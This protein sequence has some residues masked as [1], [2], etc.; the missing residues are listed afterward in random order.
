MR[1]FHKKNVVDERELMEMFQV[2]HYVCWITFWALL[3]SIFYQLFFVDDSFS[4]VGGEWCVF[5]VMAFGIL[6][7]NLKGGHFDYSSRPGWKYY[8]FYSVIAAV[9]VG[10][11][12]GC[13]AVTAGA[14]P[15]AILQKR[16]ASDLVLA[17]EGLVLLGL[18]MVVVEDIQ[19]LPRC[20]GSFLRDGKQDGSRYVAKGRCFRLTFP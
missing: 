12:G 1:L 16:L 8:L 14:V 11:V 18:E 4:Q 13:P 7:G 15:H 6:I 20:L 9:A 10:V 3:I 5:M 19:G 17:V 2:E